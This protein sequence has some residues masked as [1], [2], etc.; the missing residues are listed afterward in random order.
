MSEVLDNLNVQYTYHVH[1]G[2][3]TSATGCY[4]A[5]YHEHAS[6]CYTTVNYRYDI[7][8]DES[9]VF[10]ICP[11]CGN[12]QMVAAD[13]EKCYKGCTYKSL[14]CGKAT[15]TI[16]KYALGC[17]KTEETVESVTITY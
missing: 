14:V 13:G 12:K 4:V 6:G 5:V 1:E 11:N 7:G 10:A 8:A 2:D 15:T 17:G 16:E 9:G 3:G